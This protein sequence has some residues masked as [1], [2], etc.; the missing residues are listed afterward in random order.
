MLRHWCPAISK[1]SLFFC[2]GFVFHCYFHDTV[3]ITIVILIVFRLVTHMF[4]LYNYFSFYPSGSI[5][6]CF[7]K[8]QF[9][10]V[11]A[12][13]LFG[14]Y[15]PCFTSIC[16]YR[17]CVCLVYSHL[18]LRAHVFFVKNDVFHQP[19]YSVAL[20]LGLLRTLCP[21]RYWKYIWKYWY[22][23]RY[24]HVLC[25]SRIPICLFYAFLFL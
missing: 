23:G 2:V 6:R 8:S 21:G 19:Y 11:Q 1:F 22:S 15:L 18:C 20:S 9:L 7:V 13:F 14:W 12:Y 25:F 3:L 24:W 10:L 4:L 17:S 5:L 16:R